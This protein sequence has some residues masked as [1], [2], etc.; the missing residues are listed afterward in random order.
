MLWKI[1]R[2]EKTEQ[3]IRTGCE[4]K[5]ECNMTEAECMFSCKIWVG[6]IEKV[7]N[8]D[9]LRAEKLTFVRTFCSFLEP[10]I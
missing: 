6:F 9:G 10:A 7:R 3:D 1:R 5:G 8:E 2:N 4:D